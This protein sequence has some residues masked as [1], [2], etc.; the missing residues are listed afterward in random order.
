MTLAILKITDGTTTI[1][2]LNKDSGFLLSE[3][4]PAI[5]DFKDGGIFQNS[6][7][8]TGR[9]LV[10]YRYANA[11][12]T[13]QLKAHHVTPDALIRD[14]QELR[15]LLQK[16]AD[17][18]AT[19]WQ[20]TP[21]YIIARATGETNT[22]YCIIHTG[23]FAND[24]NPYA[25]P[26]LQPMC[27]A[28]MDSI[29]FIFERGHWLENAP[30]TVN[31][32]SLSGVQSWSTPEW[33]SE[34]TTPTGNVTALAE[35]ADGS[36]LLAGTSDAAKV[37]V[38]SDG[39]ATWSLNRTF[40]STTD[41]VEDIL[42]LRD[43]SDEIRA[44]VS[45]SASAQG[46][47]TSSNKASSWTRPIF[48]LDY[49]SAVQCV[50]T[51]WLQYGAESGNIL[52][53][54]IDGTTVQ[55]ITPGTNSVLAI[56]EYPLTGDILWADGDEL[57]RVDFSIAND[58]TEITHGSSTFECIKRLSTGRI[59]AGMADGTVY[60]SDDGGLNWSTATTT[61]TSGVY[62]MV[63]S[64]DG[65]VYGGGASVIWASYNHGDIWVQVSSDP[66]IS[67]EGMLIKANGEIYAGDSAE[68]LVQ[69]YQEYD[70]PSVIHV[71]NGHFI[72]D[73]SHIK[74]YD[75]SG[76]SYTDLFPN[77]TLPY[78]IWGA[79]ADTTD[80][81]YVGISSEAGA[82][83]FPSVVFNISTGGTIQTI[84]F[85]YWDGSI[86]TTLPTSELRGFGSTSF[87][88]D[89][90]QYA[91]V[92]SP[93]S[94]WAT[95]SIDS[96]TARWARAQIFGSGITSPYQGNG[97]IFSIKNAYADIASTQV[98]GD[99]PAL[100][101][102]EIEVSSD[103]DDGGYIN[104]AIVGL[105]SYS[106]GNRFNAYLNASD[107]GNDPS[108]LVAAGTDTTFGAFIQAP[109]NRYMV[110]SPSTTGS[111]VSVVTWT[112]QGSLV[113]EYYGTYHVFLR[114]RQSG[115]SA[116]DIDFRLR[117]STGSGGVQIDTV[118]KTL[119]NTNDNQFIDFG[120]LTIPVSSL[121]NDSDQGDE[122]NITIQCNASSTTPDIHFYDLVLIPTDEWLGDF[123]DKENSATSP[124]TNLYYLDVDSATFPKRSIRAQVRDNKFNQIK[125]VFQP[126]V[127][128]EAI[129]QAN[130]RQR[131]WFFFAR[132]ESSGSS[133]WRSEPWMAAKITINA[134]Q[135]YLGM[136]GA[137]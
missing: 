58:V 73:I 10:A 52:T 134:T 50:Y 118:S 66:S 107:Q 38:S 13:M 45:G 121:L 34:T 30:G 26:F 105:R 128:G 61:L 23:R 136:R 51:S 94:D 84:V 135:R 60:Y 122:A 77:P 21:V 62:S 89:T 64:L 130:A 47:W 49:F 19:D 115:G 129:L 44:C 102:I 71:V 39:G 24:A 93:P 124:L 56:E 78:Q 11:I 14:T 82:F 74:S 9:R 29:P 137:R 6:P 86:W 31:S 120:R 76:A 22:R 91:Y 15:R 123:T 132:T 46:V 99:L 126:V 32:V 111:W 63:E 75:S 119:A 8:A 95:T 1:D 92:F 96:V 88:S 25:Q 35:T 69:S 108:I 80:I 18:W 113:Q 133:D 114:C 55:G 87:L 79:S 97:N 40:G 110:F 112:L 7:L 72:G 54:T 41:T 67:V 81:V 42:C 85:S 48:G 70:S 104:R 103:T 4:T 117:A 65:I 109:S 2:L 131:L 43:D 12:E 98:L 68:I 127:N 106:R 28:A 57:H 59:L 83:T 116:G 17:Y 53:R 90:G 101:Q 27:G 125:N 33:D 36:L 3:W 37:Y 16:A 20:N 5:A 100:A